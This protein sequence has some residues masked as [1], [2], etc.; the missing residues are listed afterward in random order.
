MQFIKDIFG[1]FFSVEAYGD[2]DTSHNQF[3]DSIE[4]FGYQ[5]NEN[6]QLRQIDT[7]EPF[8]FE[9]KPGDRAYNQMHYE[10]LG[11]C[12]EHHIEDLLVTKYE[13]KRT[14]LPLGVD[15]NDTNIPKSH[16][17]LSQNALT[18]T[19]TL[20]VLLQ[21]SGVVR[22][23]QWSRSVIMND[24]LELGSMFPYIERAQ[25]NGWEIMVLNPNLNEIAFDDGD[26]MDFGGEGGLSFSK[27]LGRMTITGSET[28]EHHCQ[29]V[30]DNFIRKSKAKN[31]VIVAHSYGG[32]AIT[33]LA[34]HNAFDF[35]HRVTALALTDSVHS[36]T[37]IKG[38][39]VIEWFN[40]HS[41]HWVASKETL[42]KVMPYHTKD[43]GCPCV[44]AGHSKHEFTSGTARDS[45]MLFLETQIN[46]TDRD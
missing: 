34:T 17:Y 11:T 29:Y 31:L 18:S 10:A 14:I 42:D 3:P 27:K 1:S 9:V 6:G 7:D 16:I 13:L 28:P 20:L 45:V 33:L 26:G 23:G 30:W 39:P 35:T 21:G 43:S 8:R 24:S 15:T 19:G 2:S 4:G 40:R 41:Q 25:R 32:H 36:K 37:N 22:P 46:N 12:I 5:F 38:Q 44:S